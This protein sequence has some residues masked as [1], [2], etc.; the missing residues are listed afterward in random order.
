ML[1]IQFQIKDQS[2]FSDFKKVYDILYKIKRKEVGKPLNFWSKTI[3]EYAKEVFREYYKE[4]KTERDIDS[5]GFKATI[6]Y[7]EFGLEVDLDNLI[8]LENGQ[9]RLEYTALA[10]P[11]GGMDRLLL[12]LVAYDLIPLESFNG[13]SVIEFN[14][15]SKFQYDWKE[16][17]EKTES[18]KAQFKG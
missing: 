7:I 12:F 15:V 9:A 5:Y 13:F 16:L 14:W 10:F 3:P 11:Y 18:Y 1:Y 4:E 2:K 8:E 6:N 17:E